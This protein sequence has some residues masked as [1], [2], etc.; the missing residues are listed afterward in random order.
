MERIKSDF[1]CVEDYSVSETTLEQV[2][3]SFAKMQRKEKNEKEEE[4]ERNSVKEE[5]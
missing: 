3:L 1:F 5:S 2:F 4:S